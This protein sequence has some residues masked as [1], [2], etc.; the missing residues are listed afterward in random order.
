MLIREQCPQNNIINVLVINKNETEYA[1]TCTK[2]TRF[3]I[4]A[5]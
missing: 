5:S 1:D 4:T 3:R 2:N